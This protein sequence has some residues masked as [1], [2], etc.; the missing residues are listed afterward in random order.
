MKFITNLAWVFGVLST[1]LL[2][3][4]IYGALTYTKFE[5]LIDQLNG[6]KASFPIKWPSLVAIVCWVWIITNW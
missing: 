5:K 2:I 6:V 4:R 1:L 3:A